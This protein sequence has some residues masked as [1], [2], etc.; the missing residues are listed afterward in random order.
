MDAQ[1]ARR[2]RQKTIQADLA[3][4]YT[5]EETSPPEWVDLLDRTRAASRS[6]RESVQYESA[7][8]VSEPD[9]RRA[10]ARRER[11]DAQVRDQIAKINEQV[12]R[13]NLLVPNS[14]FQRGTLDAEEVLKPLY[15]AERPRTV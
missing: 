10:L 6:I 3:N 4:A 9:I 1:A 12:R 11:V 8:F 7:R 2:A 5:D 15:R 13:L 14:R